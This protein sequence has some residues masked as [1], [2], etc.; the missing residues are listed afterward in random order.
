MNELNKIETFG[1]ITQGLD[2]TLHARTINNE[3]ICL[4]VTPEGTNGTCKGVPVELPETIKKINK[5]IDVIQLLKEP[6]LELKNDKVIMIPLNKSEKGNI[7]VL[8]PCALDICAGFGCINH[9][10]IGN[11]GVDSYSHLTESYCPIVF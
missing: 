1:Y 11:I 10:C 8:K 2:L 6:R 5:I 7:D 4:E 3:I 9:G